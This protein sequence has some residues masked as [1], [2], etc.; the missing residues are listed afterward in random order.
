MLLVIQHLETK[1]VAKIGWLYVVFSILISYS[2]L[3][4]GKNVYVHTVIAA[5]MHGKLVVFRATNANQDISLL[6]HEKKN[7]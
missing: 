6:Y 2:L 4:Y 7:I 3:I 5:S 1:W